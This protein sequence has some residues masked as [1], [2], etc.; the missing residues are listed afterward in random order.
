M[1]QTYLVDNEAPTTAIVSHPDLL[2]PS[3]SATFT[4]TGIDNESATADLTYQCSLDGG[5]FET[6][7]SPKTYP[8]LAIGEHTFE[9][10]AID[11]L[12]HVDA[13]PATFTW[14]VAH[15]IFLPLVRR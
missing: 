6:C 10:R 12:G 14:T 1:D 5:A 15:K 11:E 13:T 9:V 2:S 4:F 3:D 7:T 8:N